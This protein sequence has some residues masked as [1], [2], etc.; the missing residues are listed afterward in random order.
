[1]AENTKKPTIS[2]SEYLFMQ[3]AKRFHEGLNF[4]S[5]SNIL[6]TMTE[7]QVTNITKHTFSNLLNDLKSIPDTIIT[8]EPVTGTNHLNMS[9]K[10]KGSSAKL[11]S[12]GPKGGIILGD[13]LIM[14]SY[15]N[16][17]DLALHK[18]LHNEAM[19]IYNTNFTIY[20]AKKLHNINR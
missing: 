9:I 10:S 4:L 7:E 5:T 17:E 6:S 3:K 18:S 11:L 20:Q 15:T 12:I 2:P 16:R 8:F 19:K 13:K 1:M 14:D